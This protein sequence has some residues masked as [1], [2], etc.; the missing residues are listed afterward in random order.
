M[1][2][3]A[4]ERALPDDTPLGWMK[5]AACK[6]Q[7]DLFF[8]PSS[9]SGRT[10]EVDIQ[11]ERAKN[12]CRQCPVLAQCAGYA[13]TLPNEVVGVWAAMTQRDRRNRKHAES[14]RI[15]RTRRTG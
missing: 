6:G 12:I 4:L 8:P 9:T 3:E 7:V 14:D 13:L 5:E 15:P 10:S 11:V 1:S 2:A